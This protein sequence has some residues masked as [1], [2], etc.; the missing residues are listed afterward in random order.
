[1]FCGSRGQLFSTRMR[2]IF[3]FFNMEPWINPILLYHRIVNH[4]DKV[5]LTSG[6]RKIPV[7][8]ISYSIGIILSPLET[9]TIKTT[10]FN[11]TL[12]LVMLSSFVVMLNDNNIFIKLNELKHGNTIKE[13]NL[14]L[15]LNK[16]NSLHKEKYYVTWYFFCLDIDQS[17]IILNQHF[18]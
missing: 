16:K 7:Y 8:W 12:C 9:Y 4:I 3:A 11:C 5:S 1:M 10:F 15:V 14:F 18:M 13:N 17:S 2:N 6:S